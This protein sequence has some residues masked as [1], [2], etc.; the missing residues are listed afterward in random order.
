M[1]GTR[2]LDFCRSRI[3]SMMMIATAMPAPMTRSRLADTR[4]VEIVMPETG[5]FDEPTRPAM[6]EA[7]AENRKPA[8]ITT[9]DMTAETAIEWTKWL[10]MKNSGMTDAAM[11]IK[12][13]FI[14][15]SC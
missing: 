8:T 1:T 14:G 12:M 5:L 15:M 6:Y 3:M 13:M 11:R 2:K 4:I 7:T 9:I 10:K